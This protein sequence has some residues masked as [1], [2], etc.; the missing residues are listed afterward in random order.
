MEPAHALAWSVVAYHLDVP[1]L[2]RLSLTCVALHRA[3]SE[4]H[5]VWRTR[6]GSRAEAVR[7]LYALHSFV[8]PLAGAAA[9]P[10]VQ[11]EK[12][13]MTVPDIGGIAYFHSL[14]PDIV[15]ICL[16][17]L[18]DPAFHQR[19]VKGPVE[20][21]IFAL[22]NVRQHTVRSISLPQLTEAE[23]QHG[24]AV[25]MR[26]DVGR[27]RYCCSR[28]FH[29]TGQQEVVFECTSGF[30]TEGEIN[31]RC[32][33][34][35]QLGGKSNFASGVLFCEGTDGRQYA[36]GCGVTLQ[37]VDLE[38]MQPVTEKPLDMSAM[39]TKGP[40]PSTL[41]LRGHRSARLLHVP[42]LEP[43]DHPLSKLASRDVLANKQVHFGG[44]EFALEFSTGRVLN[45]SA[46]CVDTQLPGINP[47]YMYSPTL[48]AVDS[49]YGTHARALLC[50][51]SL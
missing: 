11:L 34:A 13:T 37:V 32:L 26:H 47:R 51:R 3:F 15:L 14:A 18:A 38:T 30:L 10:P 35:M 36:V 49:R 48:L 33:G 25:S 21:G 1:S 50:C 44:E 28:H 17:S 9:A 27:F 2:L 41:L 5:T 45:M 40:F 7:R 29:S 16:E 8:P 4:E 20:R 6:H 31:F 42:S 23:S 46:A 24:P 43:F 22:L 39:V 12:N 19:M